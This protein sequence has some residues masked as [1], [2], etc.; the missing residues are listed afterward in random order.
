MK[1]RG[2]RGAS[3]AVALSLTLTA[4]HLLPKL[5]PPGVTV[6]A[7]ALQG[8]SLRSEHLQL[9]LHVENPNDHGVTVDSLVAHLDL[10][11]MPFATGVNDQPFTLP[12]LGASDVMLNVTAD[13]SNA[14]TILAAAMSHRT[15]DYR[16]YGQVHVAHSLVHTL[17]FAHTGRLR[18]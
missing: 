12:A 14:V 1:R 2:W 10:L 17:D 4:C 8:G 11:G 9:R 15:L 13:M 5:Q 16:I 18:L 6:S 3:A 7:V